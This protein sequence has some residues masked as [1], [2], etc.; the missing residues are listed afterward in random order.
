MKKI[1]ILATLIVA[2]FYATAVDVGGSVTVGSD[3]LWRGASQKGSPAIS[4]GVEV[5]HNGLYAGTWVSQVD[6]GDNSDYEYDFYA[7]Y[8]YDITDEL[9]VDVGLI[10]YNFNNES[11][12]Q[13]EEWYTSATFRRFTAIY[14]QDLDNS[15]NHFAEYS[16]EIPVDNVSLSVFY[17]D[18]MD[19]YGIN[20]SKDINSYTLAATVGQGRDEL[21]SEAVVSVA[22]NF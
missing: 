9:S 2:P 16:Y 4:A 1:L 3:Y 12:N 6:Y 17:Q 18:P 21:G 11:G 22:Y 20:I 10:Q 5:G 7:G 13:L 14:Y 19:F 8:G 15:D